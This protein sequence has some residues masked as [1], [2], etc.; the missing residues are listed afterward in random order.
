MPKKTSPEVIQ[1]IKEL[2]DYPT[3][4][5]IRRL[6]A[7][8]IKVST[9]TVAIQL[10]PKRMVKYICRECWSEFIWR[11][12]GWLCPDCLKTRKY[13]Q[14]DNNSKDSRELITQENNKTKE[15][16]WL[17]DRQIYDLLQEY[18]HSDIRKCFLWGKQIKK[19]PTYEFKRVDYS[20]KAV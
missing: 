16:T 7:E 18:C 2:W 10:S 8:W 3:A 6:S 11:C 1:R 15:M 5:I 4:E 14:K 17:S 20:K 13:Y 19:L 12:R 9:T